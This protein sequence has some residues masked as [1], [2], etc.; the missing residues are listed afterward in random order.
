MALR[1]N[2]KIH[3]TCKFPF[4]RS[5]VV[6]VFGRLWRFSQYL[7]GY[8]WCSG[9]KRHLKLLK[10][11][12]DKGCVA[13][14]AQ[15]LHSQSHIWFSNPLVKLPSPSNSCFAITAWHPTSY[16]TPAVSAPLGM[17]LLPAQTSCFQ[18]SGPQAINSKAPARVLLRTTAC[19]QGS[20]NWR[21]RSTSSLES[22]TAT[23]CPWPHSNVLPEAVAPC[24]AFVLAYVS[25]WARSACTR[26]ST[27][28]SPAT[29]MNGYR[30]YRHVQASSLLTA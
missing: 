19:T 8:L 3:K 11:F 16:A 9:S 25:A 23:R 13:W 6:A 28:S 21:S 12:A 30:M 5:F 26:I 17:L 4:P 7:R 2:S 27:V 24:Q 29:A 15:K 20:A 14:V 10:C 1:E 22:A 18:E